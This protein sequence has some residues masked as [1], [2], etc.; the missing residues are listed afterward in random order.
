MTNEK[1]PFSHEMHVGAPTQTPTSNRAAPE[2]PGQGEAWDVTSRTGPGGSVP[3]TSR[4]STGTTRIR[5]SSRS[6]RRAATTRVLSPDNTD[7]K[8]QFSTTRGETLQTDMNQR[9]RRKYAKS[10]RDVAEYAADGAAAIE[11]EDDT[12]AQL[13]VVQLSLIGASTTK[14]LVQIFLD[15]AQVE[16]AK[17]QLD[18]A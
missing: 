13:K 5:N 4:G 18:S 14:E 12:T 1:L 16:K 9:E 10:L 2:P 8:Q 3:A 17:Q 15:A 11:A 7:E 6:P